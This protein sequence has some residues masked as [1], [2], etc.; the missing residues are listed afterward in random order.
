MSR[1][2][3]QLGHGYGAVPVSI[4]TQ[5]DGNTVF[6]GAVPTTDVPVP[7]AYPD[8]QLG[9]PCFDWV[10]PVLNFV[11]TKSLS[12]SVT[13]GV[14]QIGQTLAQNNVGNT[15]QYGPVYLANIGNVVFSDPLSQVSINGAAQTRPDDPA[16]E[17]QWGWTL[18]AGDTLTATLNI[19]VPYWPTGFIEFDT[20]PATIAPGS[21]GTFEVSWLSEDPAWPYPKTMTWNILNGSSTDQDF[22]A[23][24]GSVVF[25]SANSSFSVSTVAHDP[26]Q[27]PKNFNV[28]ITNS[29]GQGLA[30][31]PTINIA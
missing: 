17:G 5:I 7:G 25:D 4:V 13:N 9:L 21:S 19:N 18:Q 24:V 15:D 11:G 14:F 8:Q 2:F 26:A 22:D 20:V 29:R 23:V 31:S 1:I 12:I 16:L 28:S 10:E 30:L 6:D 3:R 27:G